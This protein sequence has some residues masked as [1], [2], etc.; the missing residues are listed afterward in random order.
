[1]VPEK[2]F[3]LGDTIENE[4]VPGDSSQRKS[5]AVLDIEAEVKLAFDSR[6]DSGDSASFTRRIKIFRSRKVMRESSV[7][8]CVQLKTC[9]RLFL[10]VIICRYW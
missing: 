10:C 4:L 2:P 5:G 3:R 6:R 9:T 8:K 1:V 7:R